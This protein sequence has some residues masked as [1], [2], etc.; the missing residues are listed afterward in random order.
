MTA[1]HYLTSADTALVTVINVNVFPRLPGPPPVVVI[2]LAASLRPR[3]P[4]GHS[5]GFR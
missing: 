1:E 4:T 3:K 2:P 5:L